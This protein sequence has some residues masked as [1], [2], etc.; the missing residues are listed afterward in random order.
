MIKKCGVSTINT[1]KKAMKTKLL[2]VVIALLVISNVTLMIF[3]IKNQN[4][5]NIGYKNSNQVES[6]F[7]NNINQPVS[8]PKHNRDELRN[9][10][11][12]KTQNQVI[13][14]IGKPESSQ[15]VSGGKQMWYYHSGISYDP[16]TDIV[17]YQVQVIFINGICVMVNF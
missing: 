11:I 6:S 12:G 14:I 15:D 7:N 5:N 17:D 4:K 2:Y 10:I 8:K 16:V 13:E 9:L 3:L 1:D